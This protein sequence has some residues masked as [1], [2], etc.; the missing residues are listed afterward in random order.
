MGIFPPLCS[1]REER[2]GEPELGE[3][4]GPQVRAERGYAKQLDTHFLSSVVWSFPSPA[5]VE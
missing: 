4:E 2:G 1:Q 3:G 5:D